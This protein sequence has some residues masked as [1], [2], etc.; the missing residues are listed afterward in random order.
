M[1]R[2]GAYFRNFLLGFFTLALVAGLIAGDYYWRHEPSRKATRLLNK[3]GIPID[4]ASAVKAA[5]EGRLYLLEQLEQARV[6][7]GAADGEGETPLLS[8]IR[9]RKD[10]AID[11]LLLRERVLLTVDAAAAGDGL[12][13]FGLA[14]KRRDF[15]L[16][17]RLRNF[18]AAPD[19]SLEP[20][21]PLLVEA[22]RSDDRDL[23]DFL[24]DEG[25]TPIVADSEGDTPL[26]IAID[27]E[28]GSL[29][30][31]LVEA[32]AS[33]AEM[34]RTGDSLLTE[35]VGRGDHD[36]AEFLLKHGA[37]VNDQGASGSSALIA[38]VHSG[39]RAFCELLLDHGADPNLAGREGA[40]P[41][42]LATESQDVDTMKVLLDA[43]ADFREKDLV[44]TAFENRDLP[45]LKLLLRRGAE[46]EAFNAEGMRLLDLA[47]ASGAIESARAML[48]AGADA[49]GKLWSALRSGNDDMVELML[50]FGA[51]VS[52]IDRLGGKPLDF[53][54]K[55]GRDRTAALLLEHGANPNLLRA[56]NETWL[57]GAIRDGNAAL[58]MTLLDYGACVDGLACGDGHSLLGWAIAH[59]MEPVA[60]RLID[61]GADVRAREPSPASE[62]F[63]ETF[64]RSKTFRW[65]LQTDGDINP[66]MLAAAQGDWKIARELISAGAKP[67][68]HSRKYLWPV[69]IAA[70]HADVPMMQVMYQRDPDPEKQPRKIV[71]DLSS[72]RATLYENGKATYSTRVSTGKSGYRTPTGEYVITDKHRHHTSSLYDASMP[73][74]MR[75]SCAAFGLH[76]GNVPNYPASHG[77]IRVPYSGAK[78]LFYTC[79]VGDYVQIRY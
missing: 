5:A 14:L 71:I 52:E 70:W 66:L 55:N 57:A 13:A 59:D 38:A 46:P 27:R 36:L 4:S 50:T 8:A 76:Q 15:G 47:V 32:G 35:A 16:A 7:L 40:S 20:G 1:K 48:E 42:R 78:H 12:T 6:D 75:L 39:Q 54:L 58:A 34:G 2:L 62:A 65:H 30:W 67:G 61:A 45:G 22:C 28:E 33:G 19:V 41:L 69:N 18:G 11:F 49:G 60:R 29:I 56:E 23:L 77:C 31:R 73:Y 24:L 3:Q 25:A 9:A 63:R 79:E 53:A 51:R 17:H 26:R 64:A 21:K 72:Q 43:G 44:L 37:K 68:E 10:E 74:F